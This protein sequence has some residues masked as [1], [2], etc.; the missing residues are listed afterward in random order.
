M[1]KEKISVSD[2]SSTKNQCL[3]LWVIFTGSIITDHK[4]HS[5]R[6]HLK[7]L[8]SLKLRTLN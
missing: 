8:S 2:V 4:T 7:I 6:I 5:A 3:I 1:E